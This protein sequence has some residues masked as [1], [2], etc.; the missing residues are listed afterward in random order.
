MNN[1]LMKIARD[2]SFNADYSGNGKPKIGCA[3]ALKGAIIA[4]GWNTD[5]THTAQEI[6][7]AYRYKEEKHWLPPKMHAEIMAL[8]KIK[9]LDVDFS[10]V[11]VYIYRELKNGKKAL[12]RPCPSCM[13]KIKDLGIKKIY[14]TTPDGVAEE[15][16]GEIK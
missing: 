7:N 5:K 10:K 4:R 1:H 2:C 6:Y 8:N 13:Q 11:E 9:F 16:I 12:A 14:Y 3:V 15:R